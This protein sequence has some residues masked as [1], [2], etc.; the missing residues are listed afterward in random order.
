MVVTNSPFDLALQ[1]PGFLSVQGPDGP[2]YTRNGA[3]TLNAQ[4]QLVTLTGQKVLDDHQRPIEVHEEDVKESS[5]FQV[6]A[7]GSVFAGSQR[8]G[9]LGLVEFQDPRKLLAGGDGYYRNPDP[10][11]NPVRD[12]QDTQVQQGYL[13]GSNVDTVS[14]MVTMLVHTRNYEADQKAAQAIDETLNHAVNDIGRV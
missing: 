13:E 12:A 10:K 9:R 14:A 4:R 3:L 7:D 1:G 5:N 2:R 11:A 8:L 6:R